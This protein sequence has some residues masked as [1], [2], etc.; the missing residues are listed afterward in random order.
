MKFGLAHPAVATDLIG[1]VLARTVG[2]GRPPRDGSPSLALPREYH[3]VYAS[4]GMKV[5]PVMKHLE[6]VSPVARSRRN[7]SA[8]S[9]FAA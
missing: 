3:G 6:L 5:S 1:F 9:M 7:P 4:D 2:F 8:C